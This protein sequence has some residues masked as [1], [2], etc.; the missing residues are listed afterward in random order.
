MYSWSSNV[1][2]LNPQNYSPN[3]M[4]A[5]A[6]NT[7]T[8]LRL[9]DSDHVHYI[10]Q[11]V[12]VDYDNSRQRPLSFI[13][14]GREYPVQAVLA[15]FR[16]SDEHRQHSYLLEDSDHSVYFLYFQTIGLQDGAFLKPGF[17]VLGYRILNNQPCLSWCREERSML[18]NLSMQRDIDFYGHICPELAIG[19]T[20]CEFVQ[21]HIKAWSQGIANMAGSCE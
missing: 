4:F 7:V 6:M 13:H 3:Q 16:L 12:L 2:E 21:K 14:E 20:F 19:G 8:V 9:I 17:W 5:Q 1:D 15:R 18:I 11:K 10:Q